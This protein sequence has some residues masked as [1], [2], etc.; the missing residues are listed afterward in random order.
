[1]A[2]TTTSTSKETIG[3]DN[4]K[5]LY[6]KNLLMDKKMN[7]LMLIFLITIY[8]LADDATLAIKHAYFRDIKEIKININFDS[9]LKSL[10]KDHIKNFA[11]RDLRSKIGKPL[12]R[13]QDGGITSNI[14]FDIMAHRYNKDLEIYVGS[15]KFSVDQYI[16]GQEKYV[17][18]YY[19]ANSDNKIIEE[20][21]YTISLINDNFATDYFKV[22]DFDYTSLSTADKLFFLYDYAGPTQYFLNIR[23]EI[24]KSI[25][26]N[27]QNLKK[28]YFYIASQTKNLVDINEYL[29]FTWGA[30]KGK[31]YFVGLIKG[32]NSPA[33]TNIACADTNND[34]IFDIGITMND[35]ISP[36]SI[37]NKYFK[38]Q[39]ECY[40]YLQKEYTLM[41]KK[42]QNQ[43]KAQSPKNKKGDI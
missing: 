13:L 42:R 24:W 25:E 17:N 4:H 39:T 34:G 27:Q 8:S 26:K 20:I 6:M 32:D 14:Y 29:S 9:S 3:A 30:N 41:R 15:I 21:E 38:L 43:N 18:Y 35:T 1:M 23:Y 28:D 12:N 40:E 33:S 37:N 2:N 5:E 19:I 7:R 11:T 22:I 16:F 31:A 10:Y 36:Y